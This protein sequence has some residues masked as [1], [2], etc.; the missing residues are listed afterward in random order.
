MAENNNQK[1]NEVQISVAPDVA[2]GVY[3][4]FAMINHS[5][6][7]FIIDFAQ[8]LPGVPPQVASRIIMTP[9][10][11]KELLGALSQNVANYEKTFGT[12]HSRQPQQHGPRTIAPF[13]TGK[14]EA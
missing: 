1:P 9:E 2:K 12:I 6:S 8:M 3:S 10:H 5:P 14:G 7:D 13:G 4:N 11:A